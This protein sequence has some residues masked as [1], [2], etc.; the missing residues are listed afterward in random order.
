MK[1]VK[2]PCVK[3]LTNAL[4]TGTDK[5]FGQYF[6][7]NEFTVAAVNL[8]MFRIRWVDGDQRKMH[9]KDLTQ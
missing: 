8:P 3:P 1:Y 6:D 2:P 7:C 4:L 5:R 9:Y